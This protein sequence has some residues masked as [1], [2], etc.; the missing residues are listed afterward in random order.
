[1]TQDRV[2]RRCEVVLPRDAFY[3]RSDGGIRTVC[4]TCYRQEAKAR[5]TRSRR[6]HPERHRIRWRNLS[7][8]RNAEKC[9][10]ERARR[11]VRDAIKAGRIGKPTACETCHKERQLHGHHHDYSQPLAVTFLC[12]DC[13]AEA[14]RKLGWK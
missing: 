14:H 11:M 7:R 13:H 3:K 8:R 1:V 10:R 6:E 2:C 12:V 5:E 4:I 9:P